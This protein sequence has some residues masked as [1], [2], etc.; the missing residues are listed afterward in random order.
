MGKVINPYNFINLPPNRNNASQETGS[1]TG[2]IECYLYPRT[3]MF[4]P[5]TTNDKVFESSDAEHKSYDFYSYQDLS[6]IENPST[7]EPI[8]PGSS[9]RGEMRSLYEALTNSCLSAVD[10]DLILNKRLPNPGKI[11]VLQIKNGVYELFEAK[12][13]MACFKECHADNAEKKFNGEKCGKFFHVEKLTEEDK[14]SEGG[15]V[16]FKPSTNNYKERHY[17]PKMVTEITT[18]ATKNTSHMDEGYV[19]IGEPFQKKHH[20]T[21]AK[22]ASDTGKTFSDLDLQLLSVL[23]KLYGDTNQKNHKGYSAYK[24][25]FEDIKKNGGE[26]PVYYKQLGNNWYLS[27]ACISKEV[28]NNQ[29]SA[30]LEKGNYNP[31]ENE[32]NICPACKLFGFVGG[33]EKE[34]FS[35]PGRLRFAD[36]RIEF[37]GAFE[38][39]FE[40]PMSIKILASPKISSTEFYLQHPNF[41]YNQ[42]EKSNLAS[43]NKTG[44]KTT[45][46][47]ADMW[48]FDS[49]FNWKGNQPVPIK[50]YTPQIKGRKFYWQHNKYCLKKIS[51]AADNTNLKTTTTIRL[52]KPCA[53]E[54][55]TNNPAYYFRFS[56]YFDGLTNDEL[57]KLI[58]TLQLGGNGYHSIGQGKPFGMGS[59]KIVINKVILRSMGIENGKIIRTANQL[60]DFKKQSL[61]DAFPETISC[62]KQVESITQLHRFKSDIA[63]PTP[64]KDTRIHK[65][66]SENRGNMNK[67]TITQILPNISTVSLNDE[68]LEKNISLTKMEVPSTKNRTR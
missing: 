40:K 41:E 53:K 65:W 19:L 23:L 59:A 66:F 44:N 9:I 39:L 34:T 11:G 60:Y 68:E 20:F 14:I 49:A 5:N 47:G 30:L 58:A 24:K 27:P 8:I 52:L 37:D 54:T 25:Q 63:Y 7:C 10:N 21:I 55:S 3:H 16:H 36:A 2:R 13:F 33:N 62:A 1:L 43:D 56:V 22:K 12:K 6:T 15:K 29:L 64:E 57:D 35:L 18:D 46:N 42:L 67:P 45:S 26:I 28:Y 51:S 31:C 38:D 48:T 50:S 32:T 4:I 61:P 17:M